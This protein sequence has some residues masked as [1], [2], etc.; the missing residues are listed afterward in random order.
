[1]CSQR[2]PGKVMLPLAGLPALWH[3]YQRAR[4][5]GFITV[6]ATDG[7]SP[8]IVSFCHDQHIPC[9]VGADTDLLDRFY[10]V[11]LIEKADPIIR[12]TA[13]CPLIDPEVLQR[14]VIF[15][16]EGGYDYASV[17]T[18]IPYFITRQ[19]TL[20]W[21]GRKR[22]LYPDGLDAQVIRLPALRRAGVEGFSGSRR[23]E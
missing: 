4:A 8:Q 18:S 10:T 21:P 11:A 13:D 7:K 17:A 19:Q 9:H 23:A 1:M 5:T 22:R 14:L 15:A 6:V 2:L 16:R 12:I 20:A 3:T